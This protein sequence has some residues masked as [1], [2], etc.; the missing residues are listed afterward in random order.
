MSEQYH[1]ST[2]GSVANSTVHGDADRHLA[3]RGDLAAIGSSRRANRSNDHRLNLVPS[4][5]ELSNRKAS[6][7]NKSSWWHKFYGRFITLNYDWIDCP[8]DSL[9]LLKGLYRDTN[10][11]LFSSVLR[12]NV[13]CHS[14]PADGSSILAGAT[15]LFSNK[16][17]SK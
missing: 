10:S 14:V 11:Y 16:D 12:E 3:Q 1:A 17:P 13:H 9:E 6:N 15:S 2:P 5:P 7:A 8:A 4:A